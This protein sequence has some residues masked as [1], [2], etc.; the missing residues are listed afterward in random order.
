MTEAITDKHPIRIYDSSN[1]L[2]GYCF[3]KN[4]K[5]IIES[6]SGNKYPVSENTT[7]GQIAEI[8]LRDREEFLNREALLL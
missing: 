6:L 3:K 4:D 5:I 1:N 7:V 8:L 2:I